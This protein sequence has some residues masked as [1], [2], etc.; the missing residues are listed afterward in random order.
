M[1]SRVGGLDSRGVY[2]R[3]VNS[4]GDGCG[5]TEPSSVQSLEGDVGFGGSSGLERF[6]KLPPR[7]GVESCGG[8]TTSGTGSGNGSSSGGLGGGG[9]GGGG[10]GREGSGA[11]GF[12]FPP[13]PYIGRNRETGASGGIGRGAGPAAGVPVEIPGGRNA[14]LGGAGNAG[15]GGA[16]GSGFGWIPARGDSR[17]ASPFRLAAAGFGADMATSKSIDSSEPS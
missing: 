4:N 13:A 11:P 17:P 3:G 1:Y 12:D 10:A 6:E 9:G 14:G 7:R 15:L 5:G 2:S 16:G 8:G